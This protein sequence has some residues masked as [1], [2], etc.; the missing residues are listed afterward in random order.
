MYKKMDSNMSSNQNTGQQP[1]PMPPL[2]AQ[3]LPLF[4]QPTQQQ[5]VQKAMQPAQQPMPQTAPQQMMGQQ[6]MPQMMP[7]NQTPC[8]AAQAQAMQY[9]GGS[10]QTQAI[11]YTD[12][13]ALTTLNQIPVTAESILYLNGFLRTQIG[14]RVKVQFLI[15]T[16]TFLDRSGTLLGVGV[17]YIVINE[18]D[19]DDIVACD[20]YNIKFITFYY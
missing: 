11:Q 6:N 15:G 4:M 10:T 12:T 3:T 20:F 8:G 2:P 18:T 14:R 9:A 17:N 16:N 1:I 5:P 7:V 19:T 13:D